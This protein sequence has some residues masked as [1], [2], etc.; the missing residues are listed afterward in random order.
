M[1]A[2]CAQGS[3]DICCGAEGMRLVGQI[4]A[5][6]PDVTVRK[7]SHTGGHRY[8]PTGLTFPDGRMWGFVTADEMAAIVARNGLPSSFADRCR[9]WMG[10][11]SVGQVAERAVFAVVDDWSMDDVARTVT[12]TEIGDGWD[13]TVEV[14][15]RVFDVRVESGRPVPTITCRADGGLPAKLGREY[16]V[17][18]LSER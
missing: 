6:R 16:V 11:D 10:A 4:E 2:I 9:G 3:H 13:C 18:A 12:S 8:A 7:V 5:M 15:D 17:T 14:V 1:G